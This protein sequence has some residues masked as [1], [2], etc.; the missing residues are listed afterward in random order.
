[1]R[2]IKGIWEMKLMRGKHIDEW[3]Y[4]CLLIQ[5]YRNIRPNTLPNMIQYITN[6]QP[7][8]YL[9]HLTICFRNS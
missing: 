9:M 3:T 2:Q 1:M 5:S 7:I 8:D 6:G 4:F